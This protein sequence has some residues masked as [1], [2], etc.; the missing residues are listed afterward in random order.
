MPLGDRGT[1]V[2]GWQTPVPFPSQEGGIYTCHPLRRHKRTVIVFC[3]HKTPWR[4]WADSDVASM[5]VAPS[6]GC[7]CHSLHLHNRGGTRANAARRAFSTCEE[8]LGE[9][10]DEGQENDLDAVP[11]H[12]ETPC[13][14]ACLWY[15][16]SRPAALLWTTQ[17]STDRQRERR[18]GS[19]VPHKAAALQAHR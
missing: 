4:R 10:G 7:I 5:A 3:A 6:A 16:A 8:A 13:T 9:G 11:S 1:G 2:N 14:V 18:R 17:G 12:E 15:N 19:A